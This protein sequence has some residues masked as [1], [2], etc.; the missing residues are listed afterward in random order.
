MKAHTATFLMLMWFLSHGSL[1]LLF[2][3]EVPKYLPQFNWLFIHS[4]AI[5]GTIAVVIYFFNAL[6]NGK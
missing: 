1:L 6:R 5:T 3:F 2:C 4:L